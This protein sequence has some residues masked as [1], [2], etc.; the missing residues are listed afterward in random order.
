MQIADVNASMKNQVKQ[1]AQIFVR[2]SYNGIR[3]NIGN[4]PPFA[5]GGF[6]IKNV[7]FVTM[8]A[9]S[10][11]FSGKTQA[12]TSCTCI[13]P[14]F[15]YLLQ[16]NRLKIIQSQNIT[17]QSLVNDANSAGFPVNGLSCPVLANNLNR[18]FYT[19]T[20]QYVSVDSFIVSTGGGVYQAMIGNCLMT[21]TATGGIFEHKLNSFIAKNCTSPN[22]IE[23]SLQV[24]SAG[25]PRYKIR[26]YSDEDSLNWYVKYTD[27]SGFVQ[28]AMFNAQDTLF[29]VCA[30]SI[31][32]VQ[33]VDV[34]RN[35]YASAWY[36]LTIDNNY[37]CTFGSAIF[38]NTTVAILEVQPCSNRETVVKDDLIVVKA[39]PNPSTYKFAI[40]ITSPISVPVKIK[41]T[42]SFGRIIETR[43][44]I[45]VKGKI[46]IGASYK[47]GIYYVE[48]RQGSQVTTTKLMKM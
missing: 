35:I 13:K 9:L 10:M 31:N 12:Q 40:N 26:H 32:L 36:S 38:N 42:D 16:S 18:F 15:D 37:N 23:Y 46:D 28:N 14:L 17:V 19:L 4:K 33:D 29:E 21:F 7:L 39:V 41:V 34:A 45:P 48:I 6:K 5:A 22:S 2:P 20:P 24:P 47:A 1:V 27:C 43:T 25:C 3:K 8:L 44:E 30:S 11:A